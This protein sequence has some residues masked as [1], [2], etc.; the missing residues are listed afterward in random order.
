VI[1]VVIGRAPV[2]TTV[3]DTGGR[4]VR[5]VTTVSGDCDLAVAPGEEWL[6]FA[7][8][9]SAGALHSGRCSLSER[10]DRAGP[11]LTALERHRGGGPET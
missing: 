6:I 9:D 4:V 8:R 7:S 2:S 3:A 11:A 1:R 10:R 5:R